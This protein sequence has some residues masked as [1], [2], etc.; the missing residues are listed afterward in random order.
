MKFRIAVAAF[1]G[2]V[3]AGVVVTPASAAEVFACRTLKIGDDSLAYG[4]FS[5]DGDWIHAGD[6]STDGLRA[7]VEWETDYGRA[8]ECHDANGAHIDAVSCNYDMREEGYLRF[9]VVVRNGANGAN[10]HATTWGRWW[11]IDGDN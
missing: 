6:L 9:R 1:A 11:P 5:S 2:L 8:D 7:V 10:Q 3:G 4:C